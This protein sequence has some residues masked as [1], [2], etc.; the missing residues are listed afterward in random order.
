MLRTELDRAGSPSPNPWKDSSFILSETEA[1][2]SLELQRDGL[3]FV[4]EWGTCSGKGPVGAGR[5][6][7][8]PVEAQAGNHGGLG[9]AGD[10]GT[11]EKLFLDIFGRPGQ[12]AGRSESTTVRFRP[13]DIA[14]V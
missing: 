5:H 14:M 10:G 12:S 8:V 13:Q 7:Q 11:K 1:Q 4:A 3:S 9:Q 6:Q 2:D